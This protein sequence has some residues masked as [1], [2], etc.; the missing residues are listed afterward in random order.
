MSSLGPSPRRLAGSRSLA[1]SAPLA[2]V[3]ALSLSCGKG[4]RDEPAA[5]SGAPPTLARLAE[6]SGAATGSSAVSAAS[7]APEPE[8]PVSTAPA[9]VDLSG[10]SVP[11][12]AIPAGAPRLGA[13][14][15]LT[16]VHL[17]PDAASKRLGYL[18]AGAVVERDVS[19]A[20]EPVRGGGCKSAFAAIKP[21]GWVCLDEATLDVEHPIVRAA[22]RR[23]DHQ[24]KLPYMYGIVTRGGPVY[25]KLPT[26]DELREH[27][28]GLKKHLAKWRADQESGATYGLDVWTR[29]AKEEGRLALD[30]LEALE[31]RASDERLPW[32]LAS[33]G[34]VPSLS[35]QAKASSSV[36]I[37]QVDRRNGVAFLESLLFEGRRYNVTTDLRVVPAD[38]FRPIRGSDFHGYRIGVDVDFPFALVRRKGAKKYELGEGG[39]LREA[40]ALEYRAAVPL[41]GKQKF[42]AGKLHYE[43]KEGFWVDDRAAGRVDPAKKMPAWGKNG[44]KWIDINVT[45]QVL[46]AYEGEKAV[47]ATLVSTGEHGL[48]D[49]ESSRSTLRGI[50][51]VHT[52]YATV[53]MDSDA[54]GEEF[55]LRDVPYVQYFKDGYA[56]H[57]AYWH[58][59]FG[60][61]KSHGCVNLAPEDARRLFHWTNPQLPPGWHGVAQSL[62]GTVV[63]VHP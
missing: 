46:V 43:A 38:R 52:K 8:I 40:G 10:K 34:R 18:R 24:K 1:W 42:F 7:A 48:G 51:R 9:L 31:Q 6:A 59:A 15:M 54:V 63:F 21:A 35:G 45:K 53:T 55:E 62:T 49:P 60:M 47:Y 25:A 11:A 29:Y 19:V 57:G 12:P 3:A 44:E 37:G 61:P 17:R 28:P 22:A 27:E 4:A 13:L 2:L 41:T 14:A 56:L 50:F 36:K 26:A 39:K 30:P 33:G 16:D 32:F 20:K 23:P 5:A 58:D